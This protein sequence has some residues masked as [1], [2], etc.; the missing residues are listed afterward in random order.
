MKTSIKLLTLLA[1]SLAAGGVLAQAAG[2]WSARGGVTRISPNVDSGTLSAPS[3]KG[4][5]VAVGSDTQPTG[6]VTYMWTDNIAF[7]APIGLGF[8]HKLYGDGALAGVG[9]IGTSSVLP[10]TLDAQYRFGAAKAQ[11]RPYVKLGLTYAYFFESEGSA[12]LNGMNPLNPVG[13]NTSVEF[14][15]K[16]A[17]SPGL[18]LIF[19]FGEKYFADVAV[20]KTFLKT[21]GT[22]STGQKID[23]TLN[24][25]AVS[26]GVGVRF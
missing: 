9:Q 1:A 17:L 15:S 23:A 14:K 7:D 22:F 19:N 8:K 26:L 18:G 4:T 3:P 25:T 21:T 6:G 2:T 11:F 24:P 20:S 10:I 12:A 5:T 13:G 16:L